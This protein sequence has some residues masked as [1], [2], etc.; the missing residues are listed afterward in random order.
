MDS[1]LSRRKFLA[2]SLRASSGLV[3]LPFAA[4]KVGSATPVPFKLGIITDEIADDFEKALG[5]RR[6]IKVAQHK[7]A[8]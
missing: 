5:L 8:G 2:A 6:N 7:S 3:A 1:Y 4:Q